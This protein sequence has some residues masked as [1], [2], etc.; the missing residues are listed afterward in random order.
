MP[1]A[2]YVSSSYLIHRSTFLLQ[3]LVIDIMLHIAVEAYSNLN[4]V[5][6]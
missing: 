4:R 1:M 2:S 6:D 3:I 5:V